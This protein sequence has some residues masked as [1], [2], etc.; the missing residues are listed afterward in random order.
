VPPDSEITQVPA[1]ILALHDLAAE[2]DA[3]AIETILDAAATEPR[4][5]VDGV[6]Q[7]P[8]EPY[9]YTPEEEDLI[10]RRLQDLGYE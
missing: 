6:S 4:R 3:S 5:Q 7:T 10:V 8:V 9:G 2:L 1:T